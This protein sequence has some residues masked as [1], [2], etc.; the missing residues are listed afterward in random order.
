VYSCPL[1]NVI[2]VSSEALQSQFNL[3][4][5]TVYCDRCLSS[6]GTTITLQSTAANSLLSCLCFF[7]GT[8]IT[9]HSTLPTV[10]YHPCVSSQALPSHFSLLL[11]T[12]YCDPCV[13]SHAQMSQFSQLLHT[14]YCGPC[15]SSQPLPTH[16]SL[17][18]STFYNIPHSE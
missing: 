14:V 10:Y 13:S 4:L 12:V 8:N 6:K 7:P 15:V 17:L 9:L 16:F 2:L 5:P 18:V 1:S 3:L 11:P